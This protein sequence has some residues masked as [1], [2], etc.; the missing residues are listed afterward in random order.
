M[1]T[2]PLE[3]P[4]ANSIPP[5]TIRLLALG[6]RPFYLLAAL[7]TIIT[8]PLW[9]LIFTGVLHTPIPGIWWHSHEMIFGFSGAIIIGFLYTAGRNWTGLMTPTGGTLAALAALW[10]AGRLAMG[11]GSGLWAAIVD[12]AFLPPAGTLLLYIFIKAQNR[13]NY[14]I[15]A[16]P[17]LLGLINLLF[18][19]CT[20]RIIPVEPLMTVHIALALIVALIIVISGRV[21]PMFTTNGLRTGNTLKVPVWRNKRLEYAALIVTTL[22]LLGWALGISAWATVPLLLTAAVLHLIRSWGWRPWATRHVSML[23]ILHLSCLWIPAGLIL[24]AAA[25]MNAAPVSAGVHA[26]AIGT[27][28]G[29][30]IGMITRTALGHTGRMLIAGK[31]ETISY[32]LV[33]LA[34]FIRVVTI[35]T[36]TAVYIGGI[37]LTATL[38]TLAFIVYLWRY[39]PILIYARADGRPD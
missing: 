27:I 26:L 20:L 29:L 10:L 35:F 34:A 12:A 15:G 31:A 6:F 39:T 37:H 25:Q 24:L 5:K 8:I 22:A 21:V 9:A 3:K 33:Q 2:I 14:L 38:W 32:A 1:A 7:S 11:L 17:I 23:W 19:L 4:S 30:I 13:R 18:H 16:L 28:G 36:P